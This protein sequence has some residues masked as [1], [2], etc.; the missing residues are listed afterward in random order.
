MS[1][2]FQF[3]EPKWH[4]SSQLGQLAEK[5]IFSDSNISLIKLGIFA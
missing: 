4:G 5:N 2:D 1:S 3:L